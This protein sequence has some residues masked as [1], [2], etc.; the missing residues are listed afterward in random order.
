MHYFRPL[1]FLPPRLLY[2]P[3]L[4]TPNLTLLD[5]GSL[6]TALATLIRYSRRLL[7][8][9]V[10]VKVSER[11]GMPAT[12]PMAYHPS[13]SE[14]RR[15]YQNITPVKVGTILPRLTTPHFL[16]PVGPVFGPRTRGWATTRTPRSMSTISVSLAV[17]AQSPKQ[18]S[19]A[20]DP[21]DHDI[22]ISRA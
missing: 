5:H 6:I 7:L 10:S 20:T 12:R 14:T 15:A 2:L 19:R 22:R 1:C 9:I 8:T 18:Q 16:R 4:V 13:T 17:S 3:R 11:A 21:M